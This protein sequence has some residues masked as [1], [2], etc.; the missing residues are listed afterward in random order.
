M[1]S[2]KA[3][4]HYVV[5][6]DRLGLECVFDCNSAFHEIENC[7]K[8]KIVRIIKEQ[9]HPEKPRGIPLQMMILRAK[10]NSHR[11]YEIYEFVTSMEMS[12]VKDMFSE[13][14]QTIV[15][16]IREVGYCIYSDRETAKRVIV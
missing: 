12:D 11:N 6:W 15:D 16:A 4:N 14:P 8:I 7:E 5:M 2:K 3:T 13:D 9:S 1:S 10:M